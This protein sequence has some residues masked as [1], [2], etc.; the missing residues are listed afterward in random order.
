MGY[1]NAYCTIAASSSANGNE[2]CHIVPESKP[3]G[4]VNLSIN[5]TDKDGNATVQKV[6]V[7]SFFGKAI[8]GVLQEDPLSSRGWT[9]QKRELSNLILHYSKESICWKCRALKR[10]CSFLGKTLT[11]LTAFY[12]PSTWGES[13][14]KNRIS[15]LKKIRKENTKKSGSRPSK[16][17]PAGANKASGQ[18]P[19]LL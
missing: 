7:F 3:Y 8:T 4:P 13:G 2:S 12:E 6:R 18:A 16:K 9:F 14:L 1:S 19:R 15:S 10:A 17:T 11:H 5:E